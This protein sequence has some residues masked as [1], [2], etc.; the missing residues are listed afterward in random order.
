MD[1]ITTWLFRGSLSNHK[2]RNLIFP[3][4]CFHFTYA[5]HSQILFIGEVCQ[6]LALEHWHPPDGV[7]LVLFGTGGPAADGAILLGAEAQVL[8]E[9]EV[10][11]RGNDAAHVHST[12]Y[13]DIVAF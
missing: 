13:T 10:A 7:V 6:L 3:K 8:V 9:E 2:I 11:L 1:G 5:H 12:V 4:I